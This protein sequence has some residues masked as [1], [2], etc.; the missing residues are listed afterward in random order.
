[1][2]DKI[3]KIFTRKSQI[4]K[5]IDF[6][7]DNHSV[8]FTYRWMDWGELYTDSTRYSETELLIYCDGTVEFTGKYPDERKPVEK[9][10]YKANEGAVDKFIKLLD[11]GFLKCR[12]CDDYCDGEGYL[13]VLCDNQGEVVHS[14]YGYI[15]NFGYLKKISNFVNYKLY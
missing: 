1:M 7:E 5:L 6:S 3:K 14:F 8:F 12:N 15:Y 9:S 4:K 2:F 13:M 10:V 11:K